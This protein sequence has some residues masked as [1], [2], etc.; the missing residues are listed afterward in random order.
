MTPEHALAEAAVTAKILG[1]TVM[2]PDQI[3]EIVVEAVRR[4]RFF[5]LADPFYQPMLLSRAQDL[6]A[7]TEARLR[8]HPTLSGL[9]SSTDEGA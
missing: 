6:N 8:G 2:T 3:G 1:N 9:L 4:E 5:I 7:F